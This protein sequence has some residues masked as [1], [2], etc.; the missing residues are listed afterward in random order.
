[1]QLF[2]G[3]SM[4]AGLQQLLAAILFER[5]YSHVGPVTISDGMSHPKFERKVNT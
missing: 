5:G 3:K 2:P 1:M 4:L